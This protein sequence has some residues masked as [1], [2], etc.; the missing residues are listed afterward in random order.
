M[1]CK[2]RVFILEKLLIRILKRFWGLEKKI[3]AIILVNHY[4]NFV[5]YSCI[6]SAICNLLSS[7]NPQIEN[8]WIRIS[9]V[10]RNA[11]S[12]IYIDNFI[13]YIIKKSWSWRSFDTSLLKQMNFH[14][15]NNNKDFYCYL[16]YSIVIQRILIYFN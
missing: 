14:T 1:N 16:V 4:F 2:D 13:F 15:R 11:T 8:K 6:I 5:N 10:N 12:N 9:Q 7:I 3:S